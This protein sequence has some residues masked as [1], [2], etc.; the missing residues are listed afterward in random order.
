MKVYK[1]VS[2]EQDVEIDISAS[3]IRL[4]LEDEPNCLY[5]VL[6]DISVAWKYLQ[7][8]PEK[9]IN[10]MSDAQKLTITDGFKRALERYEVKAK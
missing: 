6:K 7:A 3:D 8:I 10:E 2:V 4:V 1:Y 5:Q 9:Y